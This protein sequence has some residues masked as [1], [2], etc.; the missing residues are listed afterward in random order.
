[1][2]N[3]R[4]TTDPFLPFAKQCILPGQQGR[5][6]VPIIL[7][8]SP[9]GSGKTTQLLRTAAALR[10]PRTPYAHID[11]AA[12][13]EVT[14]LQTVEHLGQELASFWKVRLPRVAVT[15]TLLKIPSGDLSD[16]QLEE[17]LDEAL[18]KDWRAAEIQPLLRDA[19]GI[20]ATV[21]SVPYLTLIAILIDLITFAG[22]R[23]R[24][25]LKRS[26]RSW[27]VQQAGPR[28]LAGLWRDYHET[29]RQRA[30]Q[31]L[32]TALI[33]DLRD[34]WRRH[35]MLRNCV[36]LFDNVHT[37]H[38]RAFIRML[39][40]AKA[41]T[42]DERSPDPVLV[43]ATS[44]EWLDVGPPWVRPADRRR[45]ERPPALHQ[46]SLEDWRRRHGS[47]EGRWWYPILL[48]Q[49]TED[50]LRARYAAH[51]RRADRLPKAVF[52]LTRGHPA[53]VKRLLDMLGEDV[54]DADRL[55]MR[56]AESDGLVPDV[57][58]GRREVH[59]NLQAWAA[60]RNVEIAANAGL[61]DSAGTT[62]NLSRFL[63]D[64]FWLTMEP[65][66]VNEYG[67]S[68]RPGTASGEAAVL[69]IHPWLRRLLL[70]ELAGNPALADGLPLW[71]ACHQRLRDYFRGPGGPDE[72]AAMYHVL[73]RED[74][75]LTCLQEVI[76]F[77]DERFDEC[78]RPGRDGGSMM[79]LWLRDYRRITCAP[80]RLPPATPVEKLYAALTAEP[81]PNADDG[82][83]SR[84]SV[85][86][87]LVVQ[88]W[89]WC[90]P[91]L[92]PWGDRRKDIADELQE[93][94]RFTDGGRSIL[95]REAE[96]YA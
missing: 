9:R 83:R 28:G 15:L 66:E 22:P 52:E 19:T 87:A 17:K 75:S 33:A 54:T 34:V 64:R 23:I 39:G 47:D 27:L 73:A 67:R 2:P 90:D 21:F 62:V 56:L 50:D 14:P 35:R 5:E 79:P 95:L 65:E 4:T 11:F 61:G 85:I 77:L 25:L 58:T 29:D 94:A 26:G 45:G 78:D 36:L 72:A 53:A 13:S 68:P 30:E 8:L 3:P 37:E 40:A 7:L 41:A 48:P 96:L 70:L 81:I 69:T 92:D 42:A 38:G 60:A 20:L 12:H 1:M 31:L 46:A 76:G 89:F 43:V 63:A 82:R 84:R 44:A 91:L 10:K 86:R 32:C 24:R 80:N 74:Q 59:D 16:A 93:L 6:G 57:L 88:R 71:D 55:R 18:K 51:G 49:I